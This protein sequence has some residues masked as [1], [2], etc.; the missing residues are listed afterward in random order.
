ML[1]PRRMTTERLLLRLPFASDLDPL[2]DLY[3]DAPALDN[4]GTEAAWG[5]ERT[6]R[7]LETWRG[8]YE[9]WGYSM[10]TVVERLDGEVVGLCGLCPDEGGVPE[11]ACLL[12]RRYWRRGYCREATAAVLSRAQASP[13]PLTLSARME[14]DQPSLPYLEQAVVYAHGFVFESEVPDPYS[15]KRMRYYRWSSP[16]AKPTAGPRA[17]PEAGWGA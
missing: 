5:R 2:R 8:E 1:T 9:R 16:P 3:D 13:G 17:G 12:I 14:A 10:Y 15:G 6:R 11:L 7:R 4:V